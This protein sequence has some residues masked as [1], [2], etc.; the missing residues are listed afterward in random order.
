MHLE[1]YVPRYKMQEYLPDSYQIP[2][3]RIT[4]VE[5][6]GKIV[7]SKY[8]MPMTR[9]DADSLS[10]I[11]SLGVKV[12]LVD[13]NHPT[14][15]WL[16]DEYYSKDRKMKVSIPGGHMERNDDC[17]TVEELLRWNLVRELY[18]ELA[19]NVENTSNNQNIADTM[20]V[21]GC[22]EAE[23]LD[24]WYYQYTEDYLCFF[25]LVRVL[26]NSF[27]VDRQLLPFSIHDYKELQ[28]IRKYNPQHFQTLLKNNMNIG[29]P[30]SSDIRTAT[31]GR[32]SKMIPAIMH[33]LE[34]LS[35]NS[36]IHYKPV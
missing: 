10:N 6:F 11:V 35:A 34:N 28:T 33:L 32:Y 22:A 27:A 31:T 3:K 17:E 16:G 5:E 18:E 36:D 8:C 13:Q 12:I 30:L 1:L 7:F 23:E 26:P 25:K 19:Y 9:E 24:D 4:N 20:R 21:L 15:M 14:T 2:I 29:H